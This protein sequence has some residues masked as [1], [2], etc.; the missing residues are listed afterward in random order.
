MNK[1]TCRIATISIALLA[2]A[3]RQVTGQMTAS[4]LQLS[5]TVKAVLY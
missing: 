3:A 1:L 5:P 4:Y 2:L